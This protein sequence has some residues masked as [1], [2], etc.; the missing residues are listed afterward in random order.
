MHI[1]LIII[2]AICH[3]PAPL[4]RYCPLWASPSQ[5]CSWA[6]ANAIS[7]KRPLARKTSAHT[8]KAHYLHL[9]KRCGMF[10]GIA[11]MKLT[12]ITVVNWLEW[13]CSHFTLLAVVRM[14]RGLIYRVVRWLVIAIYSIKGFF[15]VYF[16][17]FYMKP[18]LRLY[19]DYY[20]NKVRLLTP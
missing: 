6:Q 7:P 13:G 3:D 5:F 15:F 18:V 16:K 17:K 11:P 2:D 12:G 1:Y 14:W 10:T 4:A 20:N 9:P 8:Y 19:F